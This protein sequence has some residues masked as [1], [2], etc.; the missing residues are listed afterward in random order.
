MNVRELKTLCTE[1]VASYDTEVILNFWKEYE[2]KTKHFIVVRAVG[3]VALLAAITFLISVIAGGLT[4]ELIES[5]VPLYMI[6]IFFAGF[7]FAAYYLY[8]KS[9]SKKVLQAV[10]NA[11]EVTC[12]D[13][14]YIFQKREVMSYEVGDKRSKTTFYTFCRSS[15]KSARFTVGSGQTGCY[16]DEISEGKKYKLYCIQGKYIFFVR[17]PSYVINSSEMYEE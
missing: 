13:E 15:D 2:Q 6:F 10:N 17:V 5:L 7:A 1:Q 8:E 11:K 3:M 14:E 9:L 12:S 4:L 16:F